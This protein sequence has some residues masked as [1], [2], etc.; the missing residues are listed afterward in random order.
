MDICR[1]GLLAVLILMSSMVSC[2]KDPQ[3]IPPGFTGDPVFGMQAT[4][5]N[6]NISLGAGQD[7]WTMQPVVVPHDSLSTYTAIFSKE[8]CLDQ[9]TPSWTFRFY[10]ALPLVSNAPAAFDNTIRVGDKKFVLADQ[11]R[12]SFTISLMTHPDLFMS[13]YS[14]W[15]DLNGP[16]NT[17]ENEFE[18]VLG[19]QQTMNVCFQSLAFT[20]CQY[21]Q[22]I[23][24]DPSTLV[25]CLLSIEPILETPNYM[26]LN[27]KAKGTPPFQVEWSNGSTSSSIIIPLQDS[28]AE[29]YASVTVT[30][31]LGNRSQLA[32]S[33]QMLNG[34]VDACY[35]P[36]ELTSVSSVENSPLSDADRVEIIYT[37]ADG[38]EWRSSAG[39]QPLQS[40]VSIDQIV[41]YGLSPLGQPSY[42]V[43]LS[44]N[45]YLFDAVTGNSK[46]F[47]TE[48]LSVALSHP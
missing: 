42:L 27:L 4:L 22:C 5:G 1:N 28:L 38:V 24:F 15:K 2:V 16:S 33:I 29:I 21:M 39:I 32:Q 48:R 37:D 23:Y 11:E 3:D 14:Y 31:A 20:G 12:D 40:E 8:G 35:F 18:T 45:A 7:G 41:S 9:C 44:V 17:F 47:T 46:Y 34:N 10:Q 30:D 43:D 25:P 19:Y 36:I 26:S 13:G 6:E